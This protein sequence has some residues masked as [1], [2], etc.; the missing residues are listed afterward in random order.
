MCKNESGCCGA[1]KNLSL[2]LEYDTADVKLHGTVLHMT[3]MLVKDEG[4]GMENE[5]NLNAFLYF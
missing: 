5:D 2:G 1:F 4:G 3:Q